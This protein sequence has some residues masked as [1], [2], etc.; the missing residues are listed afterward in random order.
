MVTNQTFQDFLTGQ[1][2]QIDI[3]YLIISLILSAFFAYILSKLYVKYGLSISNRKRFSS[4]F[5][6]LATTTTLIIA[7]VKSSLALSLGLVGALSIVRFRAAIKEPEEL[8]FLFLT[9]A[10]GLGL[11]AG[12]ITTTITAF[13]IISTLIYGRG[14]FHK[15]E[16]N[17]N[18]YLTV[19]GKNI[20][21]NEITQILKKYCSS[22]SLKRFDQLPD[23]FLEAA[24]SV[25]FNSFSKL[26]KTKQEL[27]TLSKTL[28][29]SYLDKAGIT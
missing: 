12:Q 19:H 1:P 23:N 21:L 28:T 4:N 20:E 17:Q 9:I 11:G 15:K 6:L 25:D 7:V 22:V 27:N 8:A 10:I 26:E 3:P 13:L 24:F 16:E 14:L 5:I 2:A 18:L 29:I